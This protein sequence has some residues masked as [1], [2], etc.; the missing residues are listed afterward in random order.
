MTT[1][2]NTPDTGGIPDFLKAT[3]R[4]QPAKAAALT[5]TKPVT[6][7][8]PAIPG[9]APLGA[10]AKPDHTAKIKAA[11][12][13]KAAKDAQRAAAKAVKDAAKAQAKA[14]KAEATEGEDGEPSLPRSIVPASYKAAYAA[15]NDTCGKPMSLA[16]KEATTHPSKE[17]AGRVVLDVEALWAIA[18]ANEI[19]TAKYVGLNN[20]QKR[21]NVY[22]RLVGRLNNGHDVRIGK[23]VFKAEHHEPTKAPAPKKAKAT[24]PA[25]QPAQAAA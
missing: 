13:A 25:A 21:M 3:D 6:P 4:P 15:H 22:N 11:A 8:V 1:T 10:K 19:D 9:T 20:G 2:S 12:E 7:Q 17:Q 18:K 24:K 14:D 23:Q 5:S 16:L